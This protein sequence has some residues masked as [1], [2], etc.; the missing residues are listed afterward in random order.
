MF[1]DYPNSNAGATESPAR[2][3]RIFDRAKT[4][5]HPHENMGTY[6]HFWEQMGTQRVLNLHLEPVETN[7]LKREISRDSEI[8]T[9]PLSRE[10]QNT[11]KTS[12]LSKITGP[13]AVSLSALS[14][15]KGRTATSELH[16]QINR[17]IKCTNIATEMSQT[18]MSAAK[19]AAQPGWSERLCTS[20]PYPRDPPTTMARAKRMGRP[21][22][23]HANP[24]IKNAMSNMNP[25]TSMLAPRMSGV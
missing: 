14:S 15:S 2:S 22:P 10:A 24:A 6:G 23:D 3:S 17:K 19:K 7:R 25:A 16:R 11:S 1:F 4:F 21:L 20:A 12:T 5:T 8:S 9:A 18:N 13:L